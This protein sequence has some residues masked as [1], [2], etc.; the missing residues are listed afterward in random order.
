M[1]A[2]LDSTPGD[3][4]PLVPGSKYVYQEAGSKYEDVVGEPV[5]ISGIQAFPVKTTSGKTTISES[6]YAVNAKAVTIVAFDPKK[7]L[8]EPQPVF[9]LEPRNWTWEGSTQWLGDPAPVLIK[10]S[11]SLKG[12]R[13][14]LDREVEILEVKLDARIGGAKGVGIDVV[15]VVTYAKG[16]GMIEMRQEGKIAKRTSTSKVVLVSYQVGSQ[17]LR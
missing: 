5:D 7:P 1:A 15:Q 6:Y 9:Q 10:G 12:K 14:V 2:V 4:F 17:S 8:A 16:I 3:F 13:T 11:A